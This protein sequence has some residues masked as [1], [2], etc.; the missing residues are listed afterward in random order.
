MGDE[1]SKVLK[2]RLYKFD[3]FTNYSEHWCIGVAPKPQPVFSFQ[4]SMEQ[5][6]DQPRKYSGIG[7]Y[8]G[9][10]PSAGQL[11][12]GFD[13]NGNPVKLNSPF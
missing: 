13:E 2:M 11:A 4:W 6:L 9:Q 10:S 8:E 3:H 7:L 1:G 12:I 5:T